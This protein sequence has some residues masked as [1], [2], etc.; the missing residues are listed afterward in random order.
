MASRFPITRFSIT[1]E[2]LTR[3]R[4]ASFTRCNFATAAAP[5]GLFTKRKAVEEHA[6]SNFIKFRNYY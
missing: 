1:A 5:E 6:K 4:I 3:N 2:I